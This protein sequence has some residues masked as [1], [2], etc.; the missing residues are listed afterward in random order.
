MNLDQII[1][2]DLTVFY[3]VGVPEEERAEPQRL[4]LTVEMLVDFEKAA[5]TDDLSKTI[6]YYTVS[7]RLLG[8]GEG[9]SWRLIET[10]AVDIAE[11]VLKEFQ[12]PSVS[13]GVKKFI[14][15]EARYV[16]VFI[17][18]PGASR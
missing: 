7:A 12:P 14:L 6:D 9:R 17:T 11:M 4:L 16:E 3:R 10:L 13:V 15:T 5:R 8:F 2:K 1:I 18:R